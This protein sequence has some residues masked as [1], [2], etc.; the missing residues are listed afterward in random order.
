MDTMLRPFGS[1]HAKLTPEECKSI[2]EYHA[3]EEEAKERLRQ[4]YEERLAKEEEIRT[5]RVMIS[6]RRNMF[7]ELERDGDDLK[8]SV[9][10]PEGTDSKMCSVTVEE[11]RFGRK[12]LLVD[13]K[14]PDGKIVKER[15]LPLSDEIDPN[16]KSAKI[17]DKEGKLNIVLT[18]RKPKQISIDIL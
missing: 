11:D 1:H 3:K 12:F 18:L 15:R 9:L 5:K 13:L 7:T 10:V 8:L 16:V 14:G 17:D 2:E 6:R 4:A